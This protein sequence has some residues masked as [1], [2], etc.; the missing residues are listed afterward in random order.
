[1]RGFWLLVAAVAGAALAWQFV[2]RF[3]DQPRAVEAVPRAI[4]P[5]GDLAADEKTTI[6]LFERSKGSVVFITTTQLVRDFWSR[7]MFSIP[8]GAGSGFVWDADGHIITNNHVVQGA[9]E[10]KVRLN[11]GRDYSARLVGASPA[12]DI[13]VL[14]IRVPERQPPPLPIGTSADLKVGQKVF[15]IGNPFGLDWSLTTGIVSAIDR[16]LPAENGV[17]EHLIQTDA[18]INPGNSGGPL[19]D[20]SGRLVGI[21][22]AIFSPSGAYAG[23]GFAVP[24]D[25]VNRVVPQLVAK[26]KYTRPALGIV[27]DEQLN[28]QLARQL[29]VKGVAV[30]KIEPGSPAEA[31]GLRAARPGPDGG[32]LPGDIITAIDGKSVDSVPRLVNRLDE[33]KVG[34]TIRLTVHRDGKPVELTAT[35]KGGV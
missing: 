10:A 16:S 31:A 4:T 19:L 5:A 20:S 29:G 2:P 21:N 25:T 30:L 34:D 14:R 7:N 35:L 12:H 33:H 32:V 3:Q 22:T 8:R 1:M 9:A 26:G 23:V 15:A 11:D 24:V 18:A 28:Q 6:E 17:I 27:T 13:A